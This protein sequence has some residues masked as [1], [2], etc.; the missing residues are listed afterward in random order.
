MIESPVLEARDF[1]VRNILWSDSKNR[2]EGGAFISHSKKF[3]AA[4]EQNYQF[5]SYLSN[6]VLD[7]LERIM[8]V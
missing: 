8:Y 3:S 4:S 5:K 7:A 1:L 2:L 6:Q